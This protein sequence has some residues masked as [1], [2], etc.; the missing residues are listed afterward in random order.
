MIRFTDK[1]TDYAVLATGDGYKLERWGEITLLR[2]DPQV[3]W[4]ANYDVFSDPRIY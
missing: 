1:W 2:P 4:G 3:I